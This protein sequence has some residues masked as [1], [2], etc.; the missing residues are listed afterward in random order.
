VDLKHG[1]FPRRHSYPKWVEL[2]INHYHL[3]ETCRRL[4]LRRGGA[5]PYSWI[6]LEAPICVTVARRGLDQ[7]VV[8]ERLDVDRAHVSMILCGGQN[9]TLPSRRGIA[10]A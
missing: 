8:A 6:A 7:Y 4:T 10:L 1:Q 3:A 2:T 9:A 5:I